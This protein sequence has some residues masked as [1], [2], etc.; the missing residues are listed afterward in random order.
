MRGW[1]RPNGPN[2]PSGLGGYAKARSLVRWVCLVRLVCVVSFCTATAFAEEASPRIITMAPNLTEL[3]Y[4]MG[5][6]DCLV[7]RS[8]ACDYPAVVTNKPVAGDFG[9]PNLELVQT[10][11]PDCILFSDLENPALLNRLEELEIHH[12]VLPCESW[13]E[14]VEAAHAIGRVCHDTS[15]SEVWVEQMEERRMAL[16]NEVDLF[17]KTRQKP[18][19]YVEVWGDP[20]MVVGPNTF[21][22]DMVVLAGGIPLGEDLKKKYEQVSMEWAV[23]ENPDVILI[24][25]MFPVRDVEMVVSERP[26]WKMIKAVKNDAICSSIN[27]DWLLRPGP[28]LIYGAEALSGWLMNWQ[29]EQECNDQNTE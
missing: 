10:L 13:D 1:N 22:H 16:S 24:A 20:I 26:G 5:L 29:R 4:A 25:Y 6:E 14:L 11:Q 9:R 2:R 27:P 8:T 19:I 23:A 18:R 3:V 7:A 28:R 17:Y 21:L 12:E 15:A